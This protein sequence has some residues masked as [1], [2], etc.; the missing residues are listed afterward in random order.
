[1]LIVGAYRD[2]NGKPSVLESVR[3][4]EERIFK[5]NVSLTVYLNI[6]AY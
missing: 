6:V 4:A 3:T 5:R 2:D 1:M